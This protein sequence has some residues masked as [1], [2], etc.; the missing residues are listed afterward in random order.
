MSPRKVAG[1]A[2]LA[3]LVAAAAALLVR[4]D[5]S[6]GPVGAG[7]GAPG[8]EAVAGAPAGGAITPALAPPP[9]VAAE[10][11]P[12]EPLVSPPRIGAR[13]RAAASV[14]WEDVPVAARLSDLGPGLAAPVNAGLRAARDQMDSCFEE[15][16]RILAK[17][18]VRY[19]PDAPPMGPAFLVLRLESRAGA[20][21]VVDTEVGRLGTSTPELVECARHVLRGWPIDAPAARPGT[22]YRL[23]YLLQ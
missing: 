11:Q 17:R 1:A 23:N 7:T 4:L 13:P 15:E 16:D 5:R 21:D 18:R 19:D 22:R 6:A 9:S 3:L 8:G 12:P 10:A 14:A 20:L 2:A